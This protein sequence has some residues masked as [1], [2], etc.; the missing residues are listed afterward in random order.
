MGQQQNSVSNMI[1]VVYP[2]FT[3]LLGLQP[4]L[5]LEKGGLPPTI[6]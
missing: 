2:L 3:A 1:P 5:L 4:A 6:S